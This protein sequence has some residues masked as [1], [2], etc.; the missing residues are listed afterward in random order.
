MVRLF[1]E[2]AQEPSSGV[3]VFLDLSGSQT[4]VALDQVPNYRPNTW[5]PVSKEYGFHS[6][7][8]HSPCRLGYRQ[9][10][11]PSAAIV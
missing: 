6:V 9:K 5:A 11:R 3:L 8:G 2:Q 7:P 1:A 10:D 4:D